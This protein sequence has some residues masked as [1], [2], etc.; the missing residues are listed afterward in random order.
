MTDWAIG[1]IQ[2]CAEPFFRLLEKANFD[3]ATDTLWVAGD[4]VN[5]GPDNLSVLRFIKSLGEKAK[6]VLGNHDL[7]LLAISVGAKKLST[8][9]TLHDVMVAS[10]RDELI[11]WLRQQP[12]IQSSG[13]YLMSHAGLP[14]IWSEQ[15]CLAYANEV[16]QCLKDNVISTD[17]LLHMYGN[18]PNSWSDNLEGFDRLRAITNYLTRMRF[19]TKQGELDFSAKERPSDAPE[20]FSPWFSFPSRITKELIFGHWAALNGK[21]P[22]AGFHA[23]DTG[24]VWG[25]KLTL[26]NL[27]TQARISVSADLSAELTAKNTASKNALML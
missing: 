27:A 3:A 4:M 8:K 25:G 10:D 26:M 18:K 2:G 22:V 24:C 14:H 23:V 15:E 19:I 7:H 17:F 20:G 11:N 9:D 12:L 13:K 1:D 5:R 6:V 16:H 21:V